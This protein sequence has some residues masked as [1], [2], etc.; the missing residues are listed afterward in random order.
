MR[1]Q[2]F[3]FWLTDNGTWSWSRLTQWGS[4]IVQSGYQTLIDCEVDAG[5]Y[6]FTGDPKTYV[7]HRRRDSARP[8][9]RAVH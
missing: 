2:R 5:E 8:E 3:D 4:P 9:P 7:V 1:V 6:G